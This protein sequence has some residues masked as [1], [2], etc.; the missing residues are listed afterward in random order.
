MQPFPISLLRRHLLDFTYRNP[1]DPKTKRLH[2]TK[3]VYDLDDDYALAA[4]LSDDFLPALSLFVQMVKN[5]ADLK[6]GQFTPDAHTMID[7]AV[8]RDQFF[9]AKTFGE[10][11]DV[12]LYDIARRK[13]LFFK[14]H[15][16]AGV[17]ISAFHQPTFDRA[18][19]L[20]HE[21]QV[22]RDK[23]PN[24]FDYL[25]G[26]PAPQTQTRA[27]LGKRS[28]EAT[29]DDVYR[30]RPQPGDSHRRYDTYDNGNRVIR[31]GPEHRGRHERGN[32]QGGSGSYR[33]FGCGSTDHGARQCRKTHIEFGNGFLR[34]SRFV[35][36]LLYWYRF[37]TR[38]ESC[39]SEMS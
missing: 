19:R 6:K 5:M 20:R 24:V 28:R 4:S 15:E 22:N 13:L 32:S 36:D 25:L 14:R 29:P 2:N 9:K 26:E 21:M 8:I 23:T 38:W 31:G 37:L 10:Q 1:D 33:C 11:L 17:N 16:G 39:P 18:S 12:L 27:S 3:L 7:Y 34:A 30:R 35:I